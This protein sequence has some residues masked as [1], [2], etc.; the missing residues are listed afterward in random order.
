MKTAGIA[1]G[2]ALSCLAAAGAHADWSGQGKLGG[3]VARGNSDTETVTAVV[4]LSNVLDKWTYKFGGSILHT[5]TDEV[6]SADRWELRGETNYNFTPRAYS[7]GSVRYENDAFTSYAYQ[8]TGA[9]GFGYRFVM[10]EATKLEAQLGVGARRAEVRLT[11]EIEE[12]GILRGAMNFEHWLV[13]TTRVYNRYLI[14]AGPD[15]T[16]MQNQFGFEIKINSR[17]ALNLDYTV[18]R[19]SDVLPGIRNSDQVYTTSLM[20][21]FL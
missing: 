7:F 17:F 2:A 12:D 10:R 3:V 21:A 6:T 13:P 5:V 19:N 11:D 4:D 9:A 16:F 8:A 1:A 20:Y 14:E 18:R 15:N